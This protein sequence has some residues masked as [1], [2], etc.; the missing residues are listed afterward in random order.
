MKG[1]FGRDSLY[2]LLWGVQLGIAALCTPIITRM[3]GVSQ[4][5]QVA[6]TLAMVQVVVALASFSLQSAVQRLFANGDGDR[7][8]RRV[9]TLAVILAVGMWGLIDATGPV[10]SQ[11]IGLGRYGSTL[12]YGVAWAGLWAITNSA[13]GLIRSQD[14]LLAFGI[15]TLL[16][17]VVAEVLGMSMVVL[18]HR[19]ASEYVLGHL[20]AQSAAVGVA[21]LVTRP[22]LVRRRDLPM[23][24]GA[25]G[26]AIGLVP[27][28]LASFAL[29]TSDRLIIRADL[30]PAAVARYAVAYNI[31]NLTM[32]L[33]YVLNTAWMPR[34]FALVDTKLRAS[35]LAESR[36]FLYALLIPV[37]VGLCAAS[38]I[39]LSIWVPAGY[40]PSGLLLIVAIV[41]VTAF[42]FAGMMAAMRVL[43]FSGN[44]LAVGASTVAAGLANIGLNVY[45]VP[46]L[47]IA[48]AG[49]ATMCS[50]GLLFVLLAIRARLSL[51]LPRPRV[52]L[53]ARIP[54]A[55]AI[56]LAS[57]QLPASSAVMAARVLVA[58]GCG[59]AF[60]AML[61]NVLAP[62]RHPLAGRIAA[63]FHSPNP[64]LESS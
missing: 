54:A 30:G 24:A 32:V 63:V 23:L 50:Y 38:P 9:L 62:T 40:R 20:I 58:V 34:V 3:L 27:A 56:S 21:L 29:D 59:A 10:W 2:M 14:K 44:T 41:A 26:F 43:L 64:A 61:I 52:A 49:L 47:G 19:T 48:G 42:P 6:S 13:L 22:M 46:K 37:V 15:V 33:L 31:A 55:A 4:F 1:L 28:A 5:G 60:A 57:T 7:D 18:V 53:F 16:Q 51:R 12:V 8:A 35:V 39:I 11:A 17:S 25:L 45:L 36:D